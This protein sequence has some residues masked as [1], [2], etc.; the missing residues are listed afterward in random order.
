MFQLQSK[1]RGEQ[2]AI[3]DETIGGMKVVQAFGHERKS[4]EQFDEVKR[5]EGRDYSK[6]LSLGNVTGF[7]VYS[8]TDTQKNSLERMPSKDYFTTILNGLYD[9]YEGIVNRAE[10]ANY[11]I[12][13]IMPEQVFTVVRAIKENT[14]YLTNAEIS[15]RAGLPLDDVIMATAWLV[16]HNV[17]RQD[18]RS[19]RAGH[20]V[21]NPEAFFYTEEGP[22]A[23]EL[24]SAMIE[25]AN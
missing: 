6:L 7:P 25:V 22:C 20:A 2:T 13:R 12:C 4:L 1:T 11:L 16:V 3:I 15:T 8:F 10:L 18:R 23:R 17:I 21:R 19:V 24:I 9:C 5:L 14:H